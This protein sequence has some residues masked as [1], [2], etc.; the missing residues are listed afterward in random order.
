VIQPKLEREDSNDLLYLMSERL[1]SEHPDIDLLVW[2]EIPTRFS[3][4][5]NRQ[6]RAKVNNLIAKMKKPVV[7]VSGHVYPNGVNPDDPES[8]YFNAAHFINADRK[9]EETYY[10]Q[11]LVPFFEFLPGEEAAPFLRELFP[12]SNRYIPGKTEKLFK[13]NE[14]VR[15]IPLI[16]YETIFPDIARRF[17]EKGGNLIVNVSNDAWLGSGNGSE[18]HFALGMFRA[19]EN[20]MPWVRV[21]NSGISGVVS[22]QGII[23]LDG[24][25][26][27]ESRDARVYEVNISP[28]RSV[29]ANYGDVFL[30]SLLVMLVVSLLKDYPFRRSLK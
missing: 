11:V 9:L 18:Y 7:L 20:H 2:P 17:V 22:A 26:D 29:Y 19:V 4:V 25:T 24:L 1:V 14:Q 5:A 30:Y 15:I 6:D 16:C 21:T 27:I 28:D 3:Y 8:E 23:Q 13:L 10:K 12:N